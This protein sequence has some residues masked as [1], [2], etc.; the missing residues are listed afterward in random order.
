MSV[1]SHPGKKLS[2]HKTAITS[3]AFSTDKHALASGDISGGLFLWDISTS[4]YITLRAPN[5]TVSTRASVAISS[6][7]FN[8]DGKTLAA[9]SWDTTV[10][11]W[12]TS[13]DKPLGTTFDSAYPRA[14]QPRYFPER[15]AC[16][17]GGPTGHSGA[18]GR[19]IEP[20]HE[21]DANLADKPGWCN[22]EFGVQPGYE[23]TGRRLLQ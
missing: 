8:V 14:Y 17:H 1:A 9:A 21:P 4:Q 7:A 10:S 2:G 15:L 23:I 3:L 16:C 18:L 11:V 12:D 5:N 22:K 19:W 6:V 20:A 13:R